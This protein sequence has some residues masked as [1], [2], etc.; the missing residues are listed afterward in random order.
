MKYM[1]YLSMF[2]AAALALVSCETGVDEYRLAPE[3]QLQPLALNEQG[4][5][6]VNADNIK[7]ESV[8]FTCSKA[9]FGQSI[10]VRYD[11]YLVKGDLEVLAGSS[12]NPALTLQK[13]VLN[14]LVVNNLKVPAETTA[15]V[16]AYVVAF[17]GDSSIVTPKSNLISFNIT[18]FQSAF[19]YVH[20]CGVFNG[21]DAGKAVLIWEIEGGSDI[22]EGIYNFTEADYA[23]GTTGFKVLPNQAW[24]GGQ[25]GFSAFNQKSA[26][27]SGDKD[28]N[29]VF[30]PGIWKVS[31]N[32]KKLT[33]A[34]DPIS[35]VALKGEMA[36]S[37]WD[38]P[39]HLTYDAVANVW[40]SA[41][42]YP[43][44]MQFKAFVNGGWYGVDNSDT[45]SAAEGSAY[46][47]GSGAVLTP[48]TGHALMDG[49]AQNIKIPADGSYYVKLYLDRTP[50]LVTFELAE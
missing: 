23:P 40:K 41:E 9:D 18:T 31:I 50:W 3:D 13:S 5:V 1:K 11:F 7:T 38:A 4:N 35:E 14:G 42:A 19:K 16:S 2:V 8:T 30:T 48:F 32:M 46:V 44:G 43:A 39:V 17:A 29:L 24:D 37:N 21:W 26:C 49:D 15:E 25:K 27:F 6:V 33:I 20:L 22:Y 45:P 34:V 36:A 47:Y 12:N 10:M 28:D